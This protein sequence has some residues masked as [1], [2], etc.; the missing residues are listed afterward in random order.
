MAVFMFMLASLIAFIIWREFS[1]VGLRKS[2]DKVA[3]SLWALKLGIA[4][5]RLLTKEDRKLNR[6]DRVLVQEDRHLAQ[7]DRAL[8][9]EERDLS[10]KER[11]E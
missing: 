11:G 3:D 10:R 4:E 5:D 2:I 7:E 9:Q 1:L 6:E 8:S